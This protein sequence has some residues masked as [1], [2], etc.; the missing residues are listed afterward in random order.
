MDTGWWSLVIFMFCT[1]ALTLL[2]HKF[3]SW[4]LGMFFIGWAVLFISLVA[5]SLICPACPNKLD[6][7][8]GPFCP[9]C[10]AVAPEPGVAGFLLPYCSACAM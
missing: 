7:T 8:L 2:T 9:E 5:F 3:L 1:M 4:C 6:E 10:G